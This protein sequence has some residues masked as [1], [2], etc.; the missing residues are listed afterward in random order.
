MIILFSHK[1]SIS[2]S[3]TLGTSLISLIKGGIPSFISTNISLLKDLPIYVQI[4]KILFLDKF[5]SSL[6]KVLR[7][8][9]NLTLS[10]I[11]FP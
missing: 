5:L 11:I 10:Q 6:L 1:I 4:S 3:I 7:V 2:F 8:P 9:T